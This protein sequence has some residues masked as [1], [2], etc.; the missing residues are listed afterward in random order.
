MRVSGGDFVGHK[1]D[2]SS[3]R[4]EARAFEARRLSAGMEGGASL[5][6]SPRCSPSLFEREIAGGFE[7]REENRRLHGSV[8]NLLLFSHSQTS[9]FYANVRPQVRQGFACNCFNADASS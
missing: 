1:K 6:P 5:A 8:Y 3:R 2:Y 4:L 9:A 7:R